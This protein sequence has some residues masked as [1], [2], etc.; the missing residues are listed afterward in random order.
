MCKNVEIVLIVM[1][2][3]VIGE[4][5][6]DPKLIKEIMIYPSKEILCRCY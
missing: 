6:E 4:I 3:I 5:W 2:V 1:E